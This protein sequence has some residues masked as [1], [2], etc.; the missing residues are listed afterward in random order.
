MNEFDNLNDEERLKAENE[1]LKMKLM[2]ENGARFE[3]SEDDA[4]LS[5]QVENEF[6]N[7]IQAFERQSQNPRYIKVFD[8]IGRPS[9]FKPVS[10]IPD[11]KIK[12]AWETLQEYL[13]RYRINLDVCSP[14]ISVREL[15]RFTTEELFEQEMGDMDIPGM[16]HGF[17]YDEFYPDHQYDNTRYAVE[18]CIAYIL[19]KIP[20]DYM[21]CFRKEDLRLND[22]YPLSEDAFKLL[23]NRFKEAYDTMED[24][25]VSDGLCTINDKACVV[26]GSYALTATVQNDAVNLNGDWEVYFELDE[27]SGYWY[28]W[29]VQIDGIHF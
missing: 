26:K 28:I 11:D 15:Y 9:H 29:N 8:K 13:N 1:F 6:L 7:Y 24:I 17:I 21:P 27:Q 12:A 18:D 20:F 5:P 16:T 14:N 23:V 22:H 3:K 25:E 19:K 4:A 2:L 10:E